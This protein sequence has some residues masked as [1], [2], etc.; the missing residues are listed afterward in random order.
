M[1]ATHCDEWFCFSFDRSFVCR[2]R[3]CCF[4]FRFPFVR[5]MNQK[6]KIWMDTKWNG[7]KSIF[8]NE[9]EK[10]K[11]KSEGNSEAIRS[12]VSLKVC[13]WLCV[14][15]CIFGTHFFFRFSAL[16]SSHLVM[17]CLWVRFFYSYLRL[18]FRSYSLYLLQRFYLFLIAGSD[19]FDLSSL[20][21][22]VVLVADVGGDGDVFKETKST[23]PPN[24][25]CA[26]FSFYLNWTDGQ[27]ISMRWV[28]IIAGNG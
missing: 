16:G 12:A 20:W 5:P 4:A 3:R 21:P 17:L 24:E 28:G 11:K 26:R 25:M 10:W 8:M 7:S 6:W 15:V 13:V 2:L 22:S 9:I 19:A 27:T 14:D 18:R 23:S 1:Y